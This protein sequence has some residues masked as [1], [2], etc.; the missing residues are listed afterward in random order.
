MR[1]FLTSLVIAI[2]AVF[3]LGAPAAAQITI[4]YSFTFE[5]TIDQDQVNSNF[6]TV[7]N[8][9]LN[10]TGGTLTGALTSSGGSLAG[11]FTGTPTMSGAWTISGAWSFTGNLTLGDAAADTFTVNGAFANT[12]LRVFDTNASHAL[13]IKPGSDITAERTLTL[14]TGDAA[15]TVTINGNPTLDDW[16]SQ[17]VKTTATPTFGATTVTGALDISGASA[18]QVSFPASQNASAGANVLDDYEE[19]TWTPTDTSGAGLSFVSAEGYYV[20]IGQNVLVWA[21]VQYP[22][23]GSGAQATWGG[24]P[25]TAKTTTASLFGGGTTYNGSGSASPSFNIQSNTTTGLWYTTAGA[26]ITNTNFSGTTIRL[27][28]SYRAAN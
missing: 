27:F 23:T 9:S 3:A 25:F 19:N 2:A 22:A 17:S 8:Q 18:G 7:G 1:K 20:K 5:T 16:F 15:R 26:A 14:T 21:S 24:L 13:V 28:A 12:S 10:R 4:P 6:T 11:T